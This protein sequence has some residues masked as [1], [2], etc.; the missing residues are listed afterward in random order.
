[1]NLTFEICEIN[2]LEALQKI[3]LKTFIDA[4]EKYNN[5]IDFKEYLDSAFSKRQI[6]NEILN[7]NSKY[8]FVFSDQLLVGYFKINEKDAQT[9]SFEQATMELE[10][11]YV[12]KSYQ[13][14]SIGK[15]ILNKVV[16]LATEN[17]VDFLWLGVWEKNSKAIKFYKNN[18]FKKIGTHHYYIGNDKQ[19]DCL[20]KL[21]IV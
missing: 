2:D 5:P 13:G 17:K 11:I 9:E 3:A 19:T 7:Q 21:N 20:L 16:H 12:L 8:Y 14:N 10:R 15:M 6:K 18:G 1:M 4:F